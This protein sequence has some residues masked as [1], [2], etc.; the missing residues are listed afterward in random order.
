[1]F[2]SKVAKT[3]SLVIGIVFA[4]LGSS[5]IAMVLSGVV[6]EGGHDAAAFGTGM[7]LVALPFLIFPFSAHLARLLGVLL[8]LALAAV[9]LW[10][11][12]NPDF[13]AAYPAMYQVGAIA[14]GVLLTA[15][16]GLALRDKHTQP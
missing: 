3:I 6:V 9:M 7:V 12:F 16:V 5:M 1:M 11:V 2:L 8:L 10:L 4:L 14:F 13:A 15:R